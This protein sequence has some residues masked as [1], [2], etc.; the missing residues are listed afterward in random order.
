MTTVEKL[1]EEKAFEFRQHIRAKAGLPVDW[2]KMSEG[3]YQ[4]YTDKAFEYLVA[5]G[6]LVERE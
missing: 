2:V 4:F 3:M 1:V 6:E 5:T